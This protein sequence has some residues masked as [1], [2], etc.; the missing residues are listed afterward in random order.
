M[1]DN[2]QPP[3]R[4]ARRAHARRSRK[5]AAIGSGVALAAGTLGALGALAPEAGAAPAV[6]NLNDNGPGSLRDALQ[7]ANDGDVIDLTGL[8]GTIHLQSTLS[9]SDAVTITGPGSSILSIS[10]DNTTSIIEMYDGLEDG[11]TLTIT[12]LTLENGN[13]GPGSA[14]YFNCSGEGSDIIGSNLVL[15]DIVAKNNVSEGL[16]GAFYFDRCDLRGN[17]TISN[18]VISGNTAVDQGAGGIWFDDGGSISLTNTTLDHNTAED[19]SGGGLYVVATGGSTQI[20]NSTFSNNYAEDDGGGLAL[21]GAPE[22]ALVA[23]STFTG[24]HAGDDGGGI[25][26][27]TENLQVLQTT[28]SG[29]TADDNGDGLYMG[30]YQGDIRSA[31]NEPGNVRS[32]AAISNTLASG[33]IIAGNADGSDDVSSDEDAVFQANDSVLGT[34]NA[35]DF[36]DLGGNQVGVTDPGLLP[37]AANGGPT[38]TM[39]LKPDSVALDAGPDPVPTFPLNSND[40]RGPGFPRVV[41]PAVDVGAYELEPVEEVV[42]VTPL[43]AG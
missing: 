40:Q 5:V 6:T 19:G 3:N 23:N 35:F 36:Q 15:D 4:A 22:G 31:D 11:Q 24:N 8:S 30:G 16:G 20:I 32:Q 26:T 21:Y 10:G 37:L 27:Y 12:G 33:T 17:L 38:Q 41:G 28:I 39:A 7:N 25:A 13:G 1:T 9:I 14:I 18:S 42:E 29:N 43:L 34:V 2:V